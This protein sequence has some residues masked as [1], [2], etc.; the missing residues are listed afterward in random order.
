MI[1]VIEERLEQ[2]FEHGKYKSYE[3]RILHEVTANTTPR[4]IVEFGRTNRSYVCKTLKR[5]RQLFLAG[6][7]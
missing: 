2:V 7:D 4:Y 3:S 1:T 5:A 6:D